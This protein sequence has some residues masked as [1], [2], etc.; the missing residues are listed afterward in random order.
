M[1]IRDAIALQNEIASDAKEWED[2][3]RDPSY[4]YSG[5]R[6]ASARE[7]LEAKK[8]L[9]SGFAQEFVLKGSA[10]KRRSRVF[11]IGEYH[12]H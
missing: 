9:L 8:L 10:R 6:L 2:H 5:A 1:R 4:L 7:Q 11:L 3:R 12:P